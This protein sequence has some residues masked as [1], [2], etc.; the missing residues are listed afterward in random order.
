MRTSR[1][2]VE[3]AAD[4]PAIAHSIEDGTAASELD[5][6]RAE[7]AS[8]KL[9]RYRYRHRVNGRRPVVRR[10]V[11]PLFRIIRR[12][13]ARKAGRLEVTYGRTGFPRR[14]A[15]EQTTHRAYALRVIKRSP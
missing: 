11:A 14:I 12:A 4:P 3:D 9:K 5:R 6:A 1:F 8:L 10:N 15:V 7:F 2:A 13:I